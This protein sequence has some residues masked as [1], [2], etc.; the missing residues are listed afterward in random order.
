MYMSLEIS[1]R[2]LYILWSLA[3]Y[4]IVQAICKYFLT[5]TLFSLPDGV[6]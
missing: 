4:Q 3:P 1:V 6:I 2:F 5:F